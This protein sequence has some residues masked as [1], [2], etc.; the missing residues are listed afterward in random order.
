V[1]GR[2]S[3]IVLLSLIAAKSQIMP[4]LFSHDG[5]NFHYRDTG[6]GT[7]FFFQHGLGG[8]V[9]QPF[10][11]FQPPPGIRL[12]GFDARGHGETRPL[13]PPEK[14]SIASF[15]DDLLALLDHLQLPQAVVGGI[16]MGAAIALNFTL[17]FPARVLGLVLSRPAWLDRPFPANVAIFSEI[18][19]LIREH[20]AKQGK[21]IFQQSLI[22]QKLRAEFPDAANSLTLQ[23]N[24]P[25]AEE[26]V[27]K[28]ER[29][30]N[31]APVDSLEKLSCIRVPALVLANKQDPIHP[32]EFGEILAKAI[33]AAEFR[34]LTSKSISLERHEAEVQTF[35]T[36]FFQ[37]HF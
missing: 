11:L 2:A 24:H 13:G 32:F 28:L 16:S 1:K 33:P 20:G 18:A 12:I 21:E 4:L 37:R 8:D 14:I 19:R 27:M 10:G 29:I 36:E 17:R 35:L 22:Y 31:D 34:E 6:F 9:N 7:P 25:R 30:P 26:T 3:A 5:L 15:A 23:F